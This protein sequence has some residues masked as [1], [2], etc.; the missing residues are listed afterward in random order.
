M[1]IGRTGRPEISRFSRLEI[2]RMHRF[3]DRAGF[4]D[5]SR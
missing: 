2:P 1:V 5:S 4:G 3:F